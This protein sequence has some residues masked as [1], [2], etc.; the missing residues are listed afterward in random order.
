M[1]KKR[2]SK[3]HA[4]IEFICL[5]GCRA[6]NNVRVMAPAIEAWIRWPI[7]IKHRTF[8]AADVHELG[9]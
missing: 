4:F 6:S 3:A 7:I 8:D 9:Q 1:A 5:I 2:P